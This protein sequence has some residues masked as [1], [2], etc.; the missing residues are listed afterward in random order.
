MKVQSSNRS[1]IRRALPEQIWDY[2][3]NIVRFDIDFE[4][5]ALDQEDLSVSS[6]GVYIAPTSIMK[7]ARDRLNP[8]DNF[9]IFMNDYD[10][11]L[12][13]DS[14]DDDDEFELPLDHSNNLNNIYEHLRCGAQAE[15]ICDCGNCL[16]HCYDD[17]GCALMDRLMDQPYID[18]IETTCT[19]I[20]IQLGVSPHP[21]AE[22]SDEDT[23]VDNGTTYVSD[24]FTDYE[25]DI[26]DSDSIS[27]ATI[28]S[29]LLYDSDLPQSL[30]KETAVHIAE[31]VAILTFQLSK[32]KDKSDVVAAFMA[33]VRG[34]TNESIVS[35]LGKT[36]NNMAEILSDIDLTIIQSNEELPSRPKFLEVL[37][38]L[39]SSYGKTIN[40]PIIKNLRYIWVCVLSYRILEPLF[41]GF[42]R[43][44]LKDLNLSEASRRVEFTDFVGSLLDTTHWIA[45]T[46]WQVLSTGFRATFFHSAE[47]YSKLFDEGV[48]LEVR[49]NQYK[50]RPPTQADTNLLADVADYL[51][52]CDEAKR[53]AETLKAP[54]VALL[55]RHWRAWTHRWTDLKVGDSAR[56]MRVQ[57]LGIHL[58]GKPGHGKSNLIMPIF[59]MIGNMMGW[60]TGPGYLYHRSNEAFYNLFSTYMWGMNL[61]DAGQNN[62]ANCSEDFMMQDIVKIGNNTPLS[63]D[64]ADLADK[65]KTPCETKLMFVSSNHEGLNADK[66]FCT[67]FA[68]HRRLHI[69]LEV[70]GKPEFITDDRI[71]S[72]KVTA[73]SDG[74]P[75][76]IHSIN[77]YIPILDKN[78]HKQF[79]HTLKLVHKGVSIKFAMRYIAKYARNYYAEQYEMLSKQSSHDAYEMCNKCDNIA[80]LCECHD[81]VQSVA[82]DGAAALG[83][84]ALLLYIS[85]KL[86]SYYCLYAAINKLQNMY[87]RTKYYI[88][89]TFNWLHLKLKYK[90]LG[91]RSKMQAAGDFVTSSYYVPAII[92]S[93]TAVMVSILLLKRVSTKFSLQSE[94]Y[95]PKPRQHERINPYM[96]APQHTGTLQL[97]EAS[98]G[99]T[100]EFSAK[101]RDWGSATCAIS[102]TNQ[103][104]SISFRALAVSGNHYLTNN[105]CIPDN[106]EDIEFNLICDPTG[107]RINRNVTFRLDSERLVRNSSKDICIFRLDNVPPR[108]DLVKYFALSGQTSFVGSYAIRELDGTVS[109]IHTSGCI[110]QETDNVFLNTTLNVYRSKLPCKT[111]NGMCGSILYG[112]G[113]QGPFIAGIHVLGRDDVG[114]AQIIYQEDLKAL[115]TKCR[116]A[117][118]AS[119][120]SIQLDGSA[121]TDEI[122][123]LHPKSTVRQ[124]AGV[125]V[126]LG[127]MN[128]P[129][130]HPR[131]H[132]GLSIAANILQEEYGF[133]L[134]HGAPVI[135]GARHREPKLKAAKDLFARREDFPPHIL[136]VIKSQMIKQ[137]KDGMSAEDWD[138]VHPIDKDTATNGAD[139]V[140]YIDSINRNTSTGSPDNISKQKVIEP[141]GDGDRVKFIDKYD[142]AIERNLDTMRSA[143]TCNPIFNAALKDEPRTFDK[144]E[145]GST[146]VFCGSP[147]VWGIPVR[148]YYLWFV[149]LVQNN[150]YLFESAPGMRAQS[151]EW[152]KLYSFLNS[153]GGNHMVAGDYSKFDKR[154]SPAVILAAYEIIISIAI[155]SGNFDEGDINALWSI[156]YDSAFPHINYFGDLVQ[157][158]GSNPSGHP[159]TVIINGLVNC[160]YMRFAYYELNPDEELDSFPNNVHLM[161]Y[162]DDNVMGVS[163]TIPWFNHTNIS[164][165]LSKY[166]V[167]YTMA[168][169]NAESIPY[170]NIT[171]VSFLKRAFVFSSEVGDYYAPLEMDSIEKSLLI[172]VQSKLITREEQFI[173]CCSSAAREYFFYGRSVYYE[174][175]G[176]LKK[177]IAQ[178]GFSGLVLPSTFPSYEELVEQWHSH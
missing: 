25:F 127:T 30:N 33:F 151:D 2:A 10:D 142:Q 35:M 78:S 170:I 157:F 37:D 45:T 98:K 118:S 87:A 4:C 17:C 26:Y 39:T 77:I 107:Q 58:F 43:K 172:N 9:S 138:G 124:V 44:C 52:R 115:L 145:Q 41:P 14:D 158:H 93:I 160:I 91:L 162:G 103:G 150:T 92:L 20:A 67:D 28:C 105:H 36:I 168:D 47:S 51:K 3:T 38:M 73:T 55:A 97:S 99:S 48:E 112:M 19:D 34:L 154:M 13:L 40:S 122:L 126:V 143:K 62:P 165:A 1:N 114:G 174:R 83:V 6:G 82:I 56:K 102:Y 69:K 32:A 167:G 120:L 156:A 140:A 175:T 130:I 81:E 63:L 109:Y 64:Q 155:E 21:H 16:C 125:G 57:P 121:I 178:L 173:A 146:R 159:L 74:S 15:V 54:S 49:I 22:S 23:E 5:D 50:S 139:G 161:T 176:I 86:F 131:S 95:K 90:T 8:L 148:M 84:C 177:V 163:P 147:I 72:S 68:I 94:G 53:M 110:Y 76:D 46:G 24:S 7:S 71:D 27:I 117:P 88:K 11:F 116:P 144:I 129:S 65:G 80:Y 136:R 100:A 70:E 12:I 31:G 79:Q 60:P 166:G 141:T 42:T 132:V 106:Y 96:Y 119:D 133:E 169:K 111:Y 171:Q 66:W 137:F 89:S 134:K 59:K 104:Q 75:P 29:E 108:K 123:P 85:E 113:P 149:R 18:Y 128:K 61:D 153:F 152:G 135:S 164:Q 101:E